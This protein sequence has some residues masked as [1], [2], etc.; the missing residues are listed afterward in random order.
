MGTGLLSKFVELVVGKLIEKRL[1][2]ALDEKRRACYSFVELLS[3]LKGFH[4]I[5]EGLIEELD[6][7]DLE[8]WVTINFLSIH[9]RSVQSL[10]TRFFALS[11]DLFLTSDVLDPVLA[12]LFEQVHTFKGSVFY[13]LADSITIPETEPRNYSI[14]YRHPSDRVLAID[15]ESFYRSLQSFRKE[16]QDRPWIWPA[17]LTEVANWEAAFPS[18]EFKTDDRGGL[19]GFVNDL[20]TQAQLLDRAI[21][22]LRPLIKDNFTLDEVLASSRKLIAG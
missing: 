20:K 12:E 14:V 19:N 17:E 16:E 21:E 10:T 11:D 22:K 1:D 9:G 5:A 6:R 4:S 13:A 7:C 2:L 8:S 3:I 18:V 15:M